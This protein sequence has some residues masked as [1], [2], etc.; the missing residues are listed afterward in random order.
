M[1]R[2]TQD[3][4]DDIASANMA[5]GLA[6]GLGLSPLRAGPF[7]ASPLPALTEGL[8][9]AQSMDLRQRAGQLPSPFDMGQSN[10]ARAIQGGPAAAV[11]SLE[12]PFSIPYSSRDSSSLGG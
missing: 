9:F 11:A 8:V 3:P 7:S 5:E 1:T 6:L 10:R 2:R 12:L 4:A